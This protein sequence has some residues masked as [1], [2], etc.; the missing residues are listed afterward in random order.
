[1]WNKKYKPKQIYYSLKVRPLCFSTIVRA[2]QMHI[3]SSYPPGAGTLQYSGTTYMSARTL[4]A[5]KYF[6]AVGWI[7]QSSKTYMLAGMHAAQEY[8]KAVGWTAQSS[9][10]Y[11]SAGTHAAQEYFKAVG[12]IT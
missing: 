12:W 10:T 5:H 4:G 2:T 8:Y 1:M 6:K 7:A 11:M 3:F 9:K